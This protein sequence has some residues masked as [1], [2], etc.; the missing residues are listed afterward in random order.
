MFTCGSLFSGIGGI[1]YAFSRA[2]F[3]VRWQVEIDPFCRKILAK[4]APEYWPNAK[5]F[6]DVKEVGKDSLEPVDVIFGGFPCQDISSAGKQAGIKEGTHSGL[7]LE[8]A[9]IIGELRPRYVLLE[10]VAAITTRDGAVVLGSLTQLRYDCEWGIISAADVGAPHQRKRWWCVA[11]RNGTGCDTWRAGQGNSSHVEQHSA[12]CQQ[13]RHND[14]PETVAYSQTLATMAQPDSLGRERQWADE[15]SDPAQSTSA[16]TSDHR[17]TGLL[18]YTESERLQGHGQRHGRSRGASGQE[19]RG[20]STSGPVGRGETVV[21]SNG[22]RP[23]EQGQ[24]SRS[25]DTEASGQRQADRPEYA[26]D[27]STQSPV[28]RIFNGLSEKLDRVRREAEWPARPG[29]AQKAWEAPRTVTKLP[30]RAA[31]LKAL[32]NSVVPAVVQ[33]IAEAIYERIQWED[34]HD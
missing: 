20:E 6:E 7:W 30:N 5:V 15:Q 10:N 31:R 29:E 33:P 21:N 18:A 3:D 23:E 17:A 27:G 26:G 24:P 32:G 11:Y 22:G 34:T 4:H 19:P 28:C 14:E 25:S 13:A 16:S 8:F 1:D 12:S 2:G 9:R